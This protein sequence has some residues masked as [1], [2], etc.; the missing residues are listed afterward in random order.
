[1]ERQPI[2]IEKNRF[3]SP[4][5]RIKLYQVT[6]WSG[7]IKV[8]GLLAEPQWQQTFPGLLYLRGGIKSVGMVRISRIIEFASE[9]FV[10]MAPYYRGNLGGEGKEDFCGEDR[11]DAFSAFGVLEQHPQV[12][13]GAIHVFGF[14][15]GG[16]MALFTAIHFPQTASLV[17]WGGVSDMKLTYEERIDLRGM[18]KR[19][20]GGSIWKYPERYDW[21]TPLNSVDNIQCSVLIIHGKK[22]DNVSIEHAY[23]LMDALE[24]NDKN[25][26]AWL[27][28]D[29]H[30]FSFGKKRQVTY[31]LTQWMKQTN[32]TF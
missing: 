11:L 21:R 18:M 32:G 12:E 17:T 23:K 6:Y 25:V 2:I 27:F 29:D 13:S 14:S 19:V 24:A 16:V 30:H 26:E 3:P 7:N 8:R 9:G 5:P 10:V 31:E 4:H 15:R 1:M 28:K 22:D 20:I